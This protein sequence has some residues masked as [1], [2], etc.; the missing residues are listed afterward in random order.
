MPVPIDIRHTNFRAA[1]S[2]DDSVWQLTSA[3]SDHVVGKH[4]NYCYL[5]VGDEP[6]NL[7]LVLC[8]KQL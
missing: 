8:E 3:A 4:K 5:M 2:E 7:D 6:E 1:S